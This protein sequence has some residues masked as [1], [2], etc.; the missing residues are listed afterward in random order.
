MENL[1]LNFFLNIEN[2]F[3]NLENNLLLLFGKIII[4]YFTFSEID[5]NK[6]FNL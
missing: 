6:D 2:L 5:T 1:F 3:N 4:I